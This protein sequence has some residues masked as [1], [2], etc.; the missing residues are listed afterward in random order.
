MDDNYNIILGEIVAEDSTT[1]QIKIKQ[2]ESSR[3]RQSRK[4]TVVKADAPKQKTSLYLPPDKMKR[5]K[6]HVAEE[7][8]NISDF[9]EIAFDAQIKKDLKKRETTENSKELQQQDSIEL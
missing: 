6:V 1:A 9:A 7:G 4:S 5:L 8:T 3:K 2:P